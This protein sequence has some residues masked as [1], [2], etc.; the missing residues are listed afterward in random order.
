M[1]GN[2]GKLDKEDCYK[3]VPKSVEISQEGKTTI[4][5]NKKMQ[6]D[7]NTPNNKLDII[8]RDNEKRN[9]YVNRCCNLETKK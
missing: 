7:R 9:T 4:L 3:H 8:I 5:W 2:K 1:H 6:S